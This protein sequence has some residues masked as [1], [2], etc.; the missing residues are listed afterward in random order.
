MILRGAEKI[1]YVSEEEY[2][3]IESQ[4]LQIKTIVPCESGYSYIT[5]AISYEDADKLFNSI[6]WSDNIF[7]KCYVIAMRKY[8]ARIFQPPLSTM[9]LKIKRKLILISR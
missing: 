4:R 8:R 9:R 2:L 3:E 1:P 6:E 7:L 5:K